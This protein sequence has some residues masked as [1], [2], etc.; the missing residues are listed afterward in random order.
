MCYLQAYVSYVRTYD[1]LLDIAARSVAKYVLVLPYHVIFKYG[2]VR[3]GTIRYRTTI[4]NNPQC[5]WQTSL[6]QWYRYLYVRWSLYKVEL[7]DAHQYSPNIK[8]NTIWVVWHIF[9]LVV[10]CQDIIFFKFLIIILFIFVYPWK[11]FFFFLSY[12]A[13]VLACFR[14]KKCHYCFLVGS[15]Q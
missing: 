2:T 8:H 3:D 7:L 5:L 10:L 12:C 9:C 4:Y 13:I 6:E 1:L 14:I 11:L 15:C